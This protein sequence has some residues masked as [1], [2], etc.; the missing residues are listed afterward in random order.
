MAR[1]GPNAKLSASVRPLIERK[2]FGPVERNDSLAC[3]T[4]HL[5]HGAREDR[6]LRRP[7]QIL[8]LYCHEKQNPYGPAGEGGTHPVGVY[9]SQSQRA[10]LTADEDKQTTLDKSLNSDDESA[11]SC[12]SC[13]KAHDAGDV[14]RAPCAACHTEEGKT[15]AHSKGKNGCRD[16][17]SIHAQTPPVKR[18][19]DC[20][21]ADADYLHGKERKA[22][23][24]G[25]PLYDDAG[26]ARP[27]GRMSCPTCHDP[28]GGRERLLRTETPKELCLTCHPGKSGMSANVH[29]GANLA[30]TPGGGG[31]KPG[32]PCSPCHSVHE[33]TDVAAQ[34]ASPD[35]AARICRRCHGEELTSLSS[36]TPQGLPPWKSL[37]ADLPLFNVLSQRDSVGFISCPTCHDVHAGGGSFRLPYEDPPELCLGCHRELETLLGSAHDPAKKGS[38]KR[39]TSC[40]SV[41]AK[42]EQ[43]SA[44]DLRV[45]GV[46][47]WNDRKCLPCHYTGELEES[48]FHGL[49]AHPVNVEMQGKGA[50]GVLPRYDALGNKGGK[51]VVCSTCHEIHGALTSA[52]SP[53]PNFLRVDPSDGALCGDCH[54]EKMAV[55]N[56]PHDLSKTY[57]TGLGPCGPCHVTHRAQSDRAL[58]GLEP[59]ESEWPPNRLCRSCHTIESRNPDAGPLLQYHMKDADPWLTPRGTIYLLRPMSFLDEL[60]IKKG[61][62]PVIPLYD[63]EGQPGPH[64]N[65]QC[66]SCH[67]PHQWSPFSPTIKPGSQVGANVPVAFTRFADPN[68]LNASVCYECHTKN[69][70]DYVRRYHKVWEDVGAEFNPLLFPKLPKE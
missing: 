60:A 49:N 63:K 7:R 29:Y 69:T 27:A 34:M 35:A 23:A 26:R 24:Q 36:H 44:W 33:K 64:G 68:A 59:G 17:H 9:L 55:L 51:R 53:T 22:G 13:H 54:S 18:C 62:A 11:L 48:P 5:V 58:W 39:C 70:A 50:R 31:S 45:R 28:H 30:K 25:L 56:T 46:G 41:H 67:E 8:C 38:K 10:A 65:L 43:P 66:I 3:A 6:L 47:T 37:T 19:P 1:H 4:C 32:N 14:A 12:V 21:A 57:P 16:C 20:H 52:G 42:G 15:P 40:H 61:I 2:G